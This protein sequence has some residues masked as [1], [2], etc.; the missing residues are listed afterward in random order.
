M[1]TLTGIDGNITILETKLKK[2]KQQKQ[3]M[4]QALFTGKIRLA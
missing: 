4:M 1:D 2:L 3:G